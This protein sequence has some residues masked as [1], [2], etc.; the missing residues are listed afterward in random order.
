MGNQ[1]RFGK[2]GELKRLD[3]LRQAGIKGPPHIRPETRVL[4]G[5]APLRAAADQ[6]ILVRIRKAAG[7]DTPFIEEL[8]RG[9]FHVYGPYEEMIPRWFESQTTVTLVAVMDSRPVGFAMVGRLSEEAHDHPGLELLAIAVE[10]QKHKLGI[11]EMLLKEIEKVV[12]GLNVKRWFLH[13]AKDNLPARR[14]FTRCG[15]RTCELREGFYPSGQDALLM[16][17]D[18]EVSNPA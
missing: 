15:Y 1:G 8:S 2:Y 3:R 10:P 5:N 13:T 11:G 17:R 9:V 12:I 4:K 7:P 6:G 18:V 14:L 16:M